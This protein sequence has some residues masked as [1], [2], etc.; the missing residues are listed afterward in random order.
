MFEHES[1]VKALA[2]SGE[3]ILKTLTAEKCELLHAAVAIPSEAGELSDSIKKFVF[4]GKD[5]DRDNVIE[6]LGDLEFFLEML[7]QTLGISRLET[8]EH[9]ISKLNKR[10][11]SGKYSDEQAQARADKA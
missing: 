4:H 9:N 2:K 5:L 11:S 1:L 7:R 6:E 8:I 10:Y 3:D